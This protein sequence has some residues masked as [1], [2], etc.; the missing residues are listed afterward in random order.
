MKTIQL[1]QGKRAIIDDVD[2]ESLFIYRWLAHKTRNV[3]YAVRWEGIGRGRQPRFMHR[4]ILGLK[5]GE[6]ADH[7]DGNGLNN[8]R[9]NLRKC[10]PSQNSMNR[11]SKGIHWIED[12]RR[13]QVTIT[14]GGKTH[15][16]GRFKTEKE[17]K[18]KFAEARKIHHGEFARI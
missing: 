1:T 4:E 7:I 5:R 2:F 17:A 6:I 11:R 16:I 12:R 14:A 13:W 10:T 15:W 18:M 9:K 3:V 8:R